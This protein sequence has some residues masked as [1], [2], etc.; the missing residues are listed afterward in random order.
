MSG[1]CRDIGRPADGELLAEY[2]HHLF[3]KEIKLFEHRLERETRV[4][5]QEEL[6]LV[7]ADVVTE[8]QCPLDD[9]AGDPTVRGVSAV[10]SSNE[11]PC[12]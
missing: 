3:T 9:L 1:S 11:G 5:H 10:K 6:A 8:S 2:R 12:P 7:V 4:V